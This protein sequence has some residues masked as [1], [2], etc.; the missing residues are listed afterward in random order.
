[1]LLR[2]IYQFNFLFPKNEYNEIL[3][4]RK[5]ILEHIEMN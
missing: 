5:P 2:L 3:G 4:N 1:M